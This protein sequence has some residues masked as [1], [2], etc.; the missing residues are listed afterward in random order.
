MK[1]E[2]F[3]VKFLVV[4]KITFSKKCHNTDINSFQFWAHFDLPVLVNI[5]SKLSLY[6]NI[7]KIYLKKNSTHCL[8]INLMILTSFPAYLDVLNLKNQIPNIG[9][10]QVWKFLKIQLLQFNCHISAYREMLEFK[11]E[12][13][14]YYQIDIPFP[15]HSYSR[16]T[17]GVNTG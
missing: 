14:K 1:K 11:D 10:Q 3:P 2:A 15:L 16:H 7:G 4:S 5:D 9:N 8:L 13:N 6:I 17:Q 12:A